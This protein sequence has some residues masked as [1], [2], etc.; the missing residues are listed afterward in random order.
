MK[1]KSHKEKVKEKGEGSKMREENKRWKEEKRSEKKLRGEER[2]KGRK[3]GRKS[4]RKNGEIKNIKI[5][6][7]TKSVFIKL[8]DCILI[9]C[10]CKKI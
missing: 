2:I 6:K 4:E 5:K 8:S 10:I 9:C 3:G 7:K 1:G